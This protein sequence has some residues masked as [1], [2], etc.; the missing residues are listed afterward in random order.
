MPPFHQRVVEAGLSAGRRF[1]L[2]LAGGYAMRAH[3]L[4]ERQSQDLDLAT[5]DQA[6]LPTIAAEVAAAYRAAGFDAVVNRATPRMARIDI[7]DPL[8]GQSVP[9]DLM[10][11]ALQ[12]HPL[13]LE[14]CPVVGL[15]DAVGLKVRAIHGRSMARDLIDVASV[16]DQYSFRELERLGRIHDEDFSVIELAGRLE[17]VYLIDD[18]DFTDY[19]LSEAEIATVRRFALDWLEDIKHRRVADG[20]I[21]VEVDA[22]PYPEWY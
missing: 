11:E 15:D 12:Q 20:D 19:G 8:T 5:N 16:A 13:Y 17:A 3:G 7:S 22:M 18:E 21:D 10:K 9:L 4:T 1:G 6:P 2:I 14:L